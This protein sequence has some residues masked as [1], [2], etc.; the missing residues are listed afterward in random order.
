M[1]GR[2]ICRPEIFEKKWVV[3][4]RGEEEREREHTTCKKI[5]P[6]KRT[7]SI[8]MGVC[9]RRMRAGWEVNCRLKEELFRLVLQYDG[10]KAAWL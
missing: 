1:E 3:E 2:R 4:G 9:G 10:V 7:R 6:F 8:A 5:Q